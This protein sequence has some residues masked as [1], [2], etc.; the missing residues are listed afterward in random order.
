MTAS[1]R[2]TKQWILVGVAALCAS[3][4]FGHGP[5]RTPPAGDARIIEFPATATYETL[6]VDLHTHSVFSDGHVWPSIRIGEALRDGLDAMAVTEHLEWQP[7]RA[8]IPHPDRNRSYSEA[9]DAAAGSQLIVIPGSEITRAAPAG[10]INAVFISDANA[11]LK[12]EDPPA[13]T[14]DPVAYYQVANRWP[15]DEAVKAASAQGAFVFWNHPYYTR[16][17]KN[18][19]ARMT[20]FHSTLIRAGHLHG[21][22]VA[23]GNTYSEEALQ[24]ALDHKLTILGVSDVHNLIDWDYPPA[25]GGHRPVTLVFTKERS[26]QA[27]KDALFAQRTVVWFKNLLIGR[28]DQ[29]TPLLSASL[30]VAD[31]SYLPD[32]EIIRLTL[33]NNSSARLMLRNTTDYTFL[34]HPDLLEVPAHGSTQVTVRPQEVVTELNLEFEVVNALTAPKVHPSWQRTVRI[35]DVPGIEA[36][37]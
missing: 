25:T 20:D 36:T 11:L 12:V 24:L 37:Q 5:A 31:A 33:Q 4:S 30:E 22:E 28:G 3:T 9:S 10:H 18:A 8:D 19:I 32:L 2:T 26:A 6:V 21:I 17:Y 15:A 27:I 35:A 29:L 34:E 13:D 14:S 7:H 23:N 1:S 16:I